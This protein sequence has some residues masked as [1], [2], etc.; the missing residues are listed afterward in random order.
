MIDIKQGWQ[1]LS[2]RRRLE[3]SLAA[4][5]VLVLV[6]SFLRSTDSPDEWS[7][8]PLPDFAAIDDVQEMKAAFFDYL[9]PIIQHQNEI[10]M[11]QRGELQQMLAKVEQGDELTGKQL[12]RLTELASRYEY[13]L[14]EGDPQGSLRQMLLRVDQLPLP[15]ALV[16]AAKESGWGRSRFAREA[17]N[18]FGQWCYSAGCG[19]IPAQRPAGEIYEV[20]KFDT[21]GDA[22]AAYLHNL[23][24]H[25]PYQSLRLMRA[26]M[27]AAGESL[28]A[29]Q[30]ADG[31]LRYS[32]R[33]EVYVEEVKS[34]IRQY[35]TFQ[36]QRQGQQ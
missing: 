29:E 27:R 25:D 28:D 34:M 18:L 1:G 9:T 14:V 33:R 15:L 6:F 10:I 12:Q 11:Q 22:I 4:L 2:G 3:L 32:Q 30:L 24:T 8:S 23:N 5:M 31:L 21:V 26:G 20:Q 7:E 35:H 36:Q 19:L 13:E 16:Q 17:N